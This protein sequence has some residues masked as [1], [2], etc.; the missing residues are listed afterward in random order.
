ME[1]IAEIS[2]LKVAIVHYWLTGMR[3]GEKVL[4]AICDIF[5]QADIYTHVY[6]PDAVSDKLKRHQIKTT[7]IQKLPRAHKWYPYYLP[8]MPMALEALDLTEY[9]LIISSESGPAKGI[10]PR[11][12]ALHI[13]YTHSPMRYIWDMYYTYWG[14]AHWLKRIPIAIMAHYLRLWDSQ[15]AL[16]TDKF[17]AN[18]SFVAQRIKKYYCRDARV[19]CPPVDTERFCPVAEPDADYYL[20]LGEL[21]QYKRPLD[22]LHAF[23]QS[24]KTLVMVGEGE[25]KQCIQQQARDNISIRSRVSQQEII[26]LFQNCRALIYTGVEDFGIIPVEVMACGRPVIALNRGGIKDSVINNVTGILYNQPSIDDLNQAVEEFEKN[27]ALFLPEIIRKHSESF[28][29]ARFIRAIKKCLNEVQASIIP[30]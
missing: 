28:S 12:D 1:V 7:F 21:C 29:Y 11:P 2:Q 9:D 3:G 24:G 4:E 19:I 6:V 27:E 15:S 25:L 30:R 22:A 26:R 20:W 8:F 13:C 5:P 10:I 14:D 23:N 18:S 17:I 16:R